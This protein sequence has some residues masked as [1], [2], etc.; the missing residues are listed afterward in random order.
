MEPQIKDYPI[1]PLFKIT[2]AHNII[3]KTLG[4]R[5]ILNLSA[6]QRFCNLQTV[7]ARTPKFQICE[8]Y[9][10]LTDIFTAF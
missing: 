8:R 4:F 6:A 2:V 5:L 9:G 7:M 3:Y 1:I 10:I